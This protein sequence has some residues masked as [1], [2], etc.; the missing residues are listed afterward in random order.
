MSTER[1]LAAAGCLALLGLAGCPGTLADREAFEAAMIEAGTLEAGA[2]TGDD[3]D[4]SFQCPDVPSGIL[5]A[6]CGL[7][8]CHGSTPAAGL[9]LVSPDVHARLTGKAANGGPGV[10]VDPGG[11]P[12][13]SV[14]YLKL[15]ASPPFGSRMPLAGDPLDDATLACVAAWIPSPDAGAD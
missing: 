8:G 15:T 12:D 14:L 9:D 7:S 5:A 11:D 10:L 1:V 13:A 4:A 3:T 2:V 6:R